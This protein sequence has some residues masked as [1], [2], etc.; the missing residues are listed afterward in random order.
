MLQN[1]DIKPKEQTGKPGVTLL[2]F[3]YRL[4]TSNPVLMSRMNPFIRYETDFLKP[5]KVICRS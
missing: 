5:A 3:L 4:K 2:Q 1:N